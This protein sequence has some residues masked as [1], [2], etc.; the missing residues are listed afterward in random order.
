MHVRRRDPLSF[1]RLEEEQVRH[2][3]LGTFNL[4]GE[5]GLL[6]DVEVDEEVDVRK[7][8]GDTIKAAERKACVRDQLVVGIGEIEGR[9]R[10]WERKG[11][12]R[13]HLLAGRGKGTVVARLAPILH[14][15]LV[16]R[17][18]RRQFS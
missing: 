2:G 3:G 4:G 7:Q 11:N 1:L 14:F 9:G 15:V 13:P 8:A 6:P 10:W 12:K 16:K 18:G 5:D 17:N